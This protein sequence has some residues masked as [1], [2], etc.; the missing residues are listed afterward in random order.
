MDFEP[1]EPK[2]AGGRRAG[3]TID[4][5]H[6]VTI[7]FS[8]LSVTYLLPLLIVCSYN[9]HTCNNLKRFFFSLLTPF[10][11]FLS[12]CHA[13]VSSFSKEPNYSSFNR[14]MQ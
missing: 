7:L 2:P 3:L 4:S 13:T 5:K 9:V 6:L 10:V 12:N 11:G 14:L 8:F 1:S